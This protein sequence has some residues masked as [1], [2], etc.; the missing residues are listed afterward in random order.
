MAC[1]TYANTERH[2]ITVTYALMF[3]IVFYILGFGLYI[4]T[5]VTALL[6]TDSS[7]TETLSQMI[8]E[9]EVS[10][11][12]FFAFIMCFILLNLIYIIFRHL[13]IPGPI[14]PPLNQLEEDEKRRINPGAYCCPRGCQLYHIQQLFNYSFAI[15]LAAFFLSAIGLVLLWL[16][17][18]TIESDLH[19]VFAT[20]AFVTFVLQQAALFL[21]RVA[22]RWY[23]RKTIP[24][25]YRIL[26][27][28]DAF[29]VLVNIVLLILFGVLRT[30][31]L[32]F[33]L[34]LGLTIY[35]IFQLTDL[36]HD[37][38]CEKT[39]EWIFGLK[40]APLI[41]KRQLTDSGSLKSSY[42]FRIPA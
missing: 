17:K 41:R 42:H 3:M 4:S 14:P 40:L 29:L 33:A 5:W 39:M 8:A 28:L 12:L 1:W 6:N 19:A 34:G 21:N 9:D 23:Q 22:F 15:Y 16:F 37:R 27:V 35:P 26:L 31:Q 11:W 18:Q 13:E 36:H 32:E 24:V 38:S 7:F 30:P 25:R 10:Y 20:I 2:R